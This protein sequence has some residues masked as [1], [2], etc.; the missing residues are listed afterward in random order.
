LAQLFH[1]RLLFPLDAFDLGF[2]G[3]GILFPA[4]VRLKNLLPL[5]FRAVS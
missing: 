3:S 1:Q 5:R 4:V 2:E